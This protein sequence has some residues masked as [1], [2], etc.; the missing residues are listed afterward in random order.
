M[1]FNNR[2]RRIIDCLIL[3]EKRSNSTRLFQVYLSLLTK[4]TRRVVSIGESEK[5]FDN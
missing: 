4:D 2:K 5:Y 1:P 3:G